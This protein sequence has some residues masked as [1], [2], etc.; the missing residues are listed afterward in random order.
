MNLFDGLNLTVKENE[1]LAPLTWLKL[2]GPVQWLVEPA[3]EEALAELLSRCR[4]AEVPLHVLGRGANLLVADEGVKGVVVRLSSDVFK[5]VRIEQESI[6]LGAGADLAKIVLDC[7]R[8]GRSGL[9]GL[10]GIPGTVGGAIKMNAGG[11]FGDIGSVCRAVRTLDGAGQILTR[12]PPELRFGYRRNN[13][14]PGVIVGAELALIEDDPQR[15]VK[16]V[17]EIWITKR[18]R[19]PL[20][21]RSPGCVFKNPP[22]QHAGQ[23]IDQAGL[24][25]AECG[26]AVVSTKHANFMIAREGA[27]STDM[28]NLIRKIREKVAEMFQIDI[29][30]EIEIWGEN[31]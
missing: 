5:T 19:Q 8:N 17:K 31:V 7:V 10:T 3:D 12:R 9:E 21:Q 24:K 14:G 6:Q 16:R 20:D 18:N 22:G 27:T 2:G 26:G 23:L 1:P 4:D 25:G 30:L 28:L 29:E 11:Q 15:I 13:L